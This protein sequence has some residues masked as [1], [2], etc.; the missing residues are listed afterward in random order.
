MQNFVKAVVEVRFSLLV[1][2]FLLVPNND[3]REKTL[4]QINWKKTMKQND[5]A[6][7]SEETLL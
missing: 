4:L 6:Y 5:V 1:R 2:F 7:T 3:R